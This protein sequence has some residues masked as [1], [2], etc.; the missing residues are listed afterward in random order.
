MTEEQRWGRNRGGQGFDAGGGGG[1]PPVGQPATFTAGFGAAGGPHVWQHGGGAPAAAAGGINPRSTMPPAFVR[2]THSHDEL[3]SASGAAWQAHL[4]AQAAAERGWYD[5]DLQYVQQCHEHDA[6]W[7]DEQELAAQ[8]H[9]QYAA[10]SAGQNQ[11]HRHAPTAPRFATGGRLY[12]RS[13]V[14]GRGLPPL[15]RPGWC[16]S[17]VG[18]DAAGYDVGHLGRQHPPMA[19]GSVYWRGRGPGP[20]TPMHQPARRGGHTPGRGRG[21]GWGW[22]AAG[23]Q[24]SNLPPTAVFTYGQLLRDYAFTPAE[25][26][27]TKQPASLLMLQRDVMAAMPSD[28][29]AGTPV[30]FVMGQGVMAVPKP[31]DRLAGSRTQRWG[32]CSMDKECVRVQRGSL[33]P[34]GSLFVAVLLPILTSGAAGALAR[35]VNLI[36]LHPECVAKAFDTNPFFANLAHGLESQITQLR[37]AWVAHEGDGLTAAGLPMMVPSPQLSFDALYQHLSPELVNAL[38][39]MFEGPEA[40]LRGCLPTLPNGGMFWRVGEEAA[41]EQVE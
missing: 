18:V 1:T 17:G 40:P 21:H 38:C 28:V 26:K 23:A 10:G 37:H 24:A 30:L 20:D 7:G 39:E 25:L 11:S 19:S 4:G 22:A 13:Q 8:R 5:E 6:Q 32:S 3:G 12:G 9:P 27:G 15:P 14:Q 29:A 34:P 31:A 16:A 36:K 2:R 33:I 35:G 41:A